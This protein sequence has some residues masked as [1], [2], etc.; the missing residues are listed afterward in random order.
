MSV[1]DITSFGKRSKKKATTFSIDEDL[2]K[3]FKKT[4]ATNGAN[5][6]AVIEEFMRLYVEKSK[7][8]I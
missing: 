1:E 6:S 8:L 2:L 7:S 3:E 5:Q 4:V